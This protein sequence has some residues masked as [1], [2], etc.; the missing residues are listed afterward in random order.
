[1]QTWSL[2]SSIIQ[3]GPVLLLRIN[4]GVYGSG[5]LGPAQFTAEY[6]K[7]GQ[8]HSVLLLLNELDWITQGTTIL[9][10]LNTVF[11]KLLK[12]EFSRDTETLMEMCLGLFY[13]PSKPIPDEV[14]TVVVCFSWHPIYPVPR[15][16]LCGEGFVN[17]LLASRMTQ[18]AQCTQ[19][20]S[21]K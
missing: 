19:P 11:N 17:P 13:A 16:K 21:D 9:S 4:G 6:L 5:K 18:K 20:I 1:M 15:D 7:I 12:L 14:R 2:S 8:Y 3:G 10:C